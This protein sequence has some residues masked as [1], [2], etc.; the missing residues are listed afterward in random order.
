ML[1][2]RSQFE[3]FFLYRPR[4]WRVG[5]G[6]AGVSPCPHYGR[7]PRSVKRHEIQTETLAKSCLVTRQSVPDAIL[8][9][10][11]F[12]FLVKPRRGVRVA[13]GARLE[14]VFGGNPN[15][16]SNPTLSASLFPCRLAIYHARDFCVPLVSPSLPE[17][18]WP[19]LVK[20]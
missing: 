9:A 2:A 4:D 10:L 14:S 6:L 20:Y 17:R 7:L 16:G 18:A 3:F 5:S 12:R 13:E 8:D 11:Q 15:V 19:F 1:N